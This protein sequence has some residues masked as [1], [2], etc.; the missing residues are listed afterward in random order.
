MS[1]YSTSAVA[2]TVIWCILMIAWIVMNAINGTSCNSIRFAT[3]AEMMSDFGNYKFSNSSTRKTAET[4][5]RA[6]LKESKDA[7]ANSLLV[8]T[9]SD[10]AV[11][12]IIVS[13]IA[14]SNATFID[15]LNHYRYIECIKD[16]SKD[17]KRFLSM[18][19]VAISI[20]K[21]KHIP[22]IDQYQVDDPSLF[23]MLIN[24]TKP[25]TSIPAVQTTIV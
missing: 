7:Y 5:A 18:R 17:S 11:Y 21:H 24:G 12:A 2:L 20:L 14:S 16:Y 25:E 22:D 15:V 3:F 13:T 23:D 8:S 10:N 6:K 1:K 4:V 19:D 9:L